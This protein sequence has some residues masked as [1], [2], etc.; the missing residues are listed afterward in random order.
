MNQETVSQAI[1]TVQTGSKL[2]AFFAAFSRKTRVERRS[3]HSRSEFSM[4]ERKLLHCKAMIPPFEG[5]VTGYSVNEQETIA[6]NNLA[7][8]CFELGIIGGYHY[9]DKND[10]VDQHA[11]AV[12]FA[13]ELGQD[14]ENGCGDDGAPDVAQTAE[15]DE[16]ENED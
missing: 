9:Y 7:E 1:V 16:Y 13:E 15:N 14:G 12:K 11:V 10:R 6:G 2:E 3:P 5:R 4:G 8:H